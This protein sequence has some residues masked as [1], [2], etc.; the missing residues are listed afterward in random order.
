MTT[1]YYVAYL[2]ITGVA[3]HLDR[4]AGWI[5]PAKIFMFFYLFIY[6]LSLPVYD[7]YYPMIVNW[8]NAPLIIN[9]Y[10]FGLAGIGL[11]GGF[12][13]KMQPFIGLPV[14]ESI[15]EKMMLLLTGFSLL[16]ALLWVNRLGVVPILAE[17]IEYARTEQARGSYFLRQMIYAGTPMFYIYA[18]C[19]LQKHEKAWFTRALVLYGLAMLACTVIQGYRTLFVAYIMISIFLMLRL[20]PEKLK[21]ANVVSAA[22]GLMMVGFAYGYMRYTSRIVWVQD[23]KGGIEYSAQYLFMRLV[24]LEKIQETFP[25]LEGFQWGVYTLRGF[26]FL[27]PGEQLS[28]GR[29]LKEEVLR[30]EFAG[31]GFNPGILGEIYINFGSS[32]IAFGMLVYGWLMA[33]IYRMY[34]C[35]Q[36]AAGFIIGAIFYFYWMLAISPGIG[37]SIMAL[38]WNAALV[39]LYITIARKAS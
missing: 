1:Y 9:G 13:I 32:G 25:L 15:V 8:G 38:M 21:L 35:S 39:L 31:G 29:W 2:I 14:N 5:S 12:A 10:L 23:Y 26:G 28:P 34:A 19:K 6:G 33:R 36:N 27:L 24:A 37:T 30:A 20:K 16:F 4:R 7:Y 3:L 18:L 11:A 17:D 22:A